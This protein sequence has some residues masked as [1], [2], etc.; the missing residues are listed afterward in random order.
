MITPS[1]AFL[2]CRD[3]AWSFGHV[4]LVSPLVVTRPPTDTDFSPHTHPLYII[5]W[6]AVSSASLSNGIFTEHINYLTSILVFM[7][8]V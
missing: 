3:T 2:G 5:T 7:Y 8:L 1:P 6:V 4:G